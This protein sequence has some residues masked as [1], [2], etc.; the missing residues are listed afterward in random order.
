MTDLRE[1]KVLVYGLTDDE[2]YDTGVFYLCKRKDLNDFT[3][4]AIVLVD[5]PITESSEE[6]RSS[7][8]KITNEWLTLAP[9]T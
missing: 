9:K 3:K 1:I 7:I 2:L 5:K 8:K 4:H 6:I